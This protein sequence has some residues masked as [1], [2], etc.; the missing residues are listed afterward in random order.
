MRSASPLEVEAAVFD[1]PERANEYTLCAALCVLGR[2]RRGAH[3]DARRVARRLVEVLMRPDVLPRL[4]GRQLS[5]VAWGLAA[6]GVRRSEAAPFL[7]L[8]A[9]RLEAD[10]AGAA[11]GLGELSMAAWGAARLDAAGERFARGVDAWCNATLADAPPPP[12]APK[13]LAVLAWSLA[14]IGRPVA[15]STA[16]ALFA[17]AAATLGSG[18]RAT[19]KDAA[20]LAWSAGTLLEADWRH[21]EAALALLDAVAAHVAAA[22]AALLGGR[23]AGKDLAQ[24]AVG[25]ARARYDA[26][27]LLAA[28]AAEGGGEA[29]RGALARCSDRELSNVAWAYARLHVR[30]AGFFGALADEL[31]QPRRALSAMGTQELAN[32]A[33]AL[34]VVRC[35]DRPLL[36][37]AIAEA[38]RRT[39]LRDMHERQLYQVWRA[40]GGAGG[41]GSDT[42]GGGAAATGTAPAPAA[43]A[44]AAA[45]V[46]EENAQAP[47]ELEWIDADDEWARA[48]EAAPTPS[49][50]GTPAS[51]IDAK[52]VRRLRRT[53]RRE[54]ERAKV[55]SARHRSVSHALRGLGI[56]HDNEAGEDADIVIPSLGI[57]LEVDGPA[58]FTRGTNRMLGHT[59]LKHRML[60]EQ[61]WLVAHVPCHEFDRIPFWSSMER[62]RYVARKIGF[63]KTIRYNDKD[64]STYKPLPRGGKFS[65][66]D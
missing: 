27:D 65:R 18:G 31:R 44:A 55:S 33:W 12:A 16:E 47:Q 7:E 29:M 58:H 10:P 34:A 43:T 2:R 62:K 42:G 41:G 40:C 63:T 24:L 13:E 15:P 57:A 60:R 36:E 26:R 35:G 50:R 28:L 23:G 20:M 14:R 59:H 8:L 21:E 32:I 51:A 3:A 37:G 5:N 66:Y 1:F 11:V 22:P 54:K 48:W 52:F 61:G 17:A 19:P 53:W 64:Y 49:P 56:L 46:D 6:V 39:D 25:A 38:Q 4:T 45:L 9:A 30:S